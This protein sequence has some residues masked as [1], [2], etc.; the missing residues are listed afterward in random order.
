MFS[1]E[2][3]ENAYFH[4]AFANAGS[5]NLKKTNFIFLWGKRLVSL[6]VCISLMLPL[7]GEVNILH[8]FTDY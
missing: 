4:H 7:T 2:A 6:S 1:S 5:Y 8:I 3:Y